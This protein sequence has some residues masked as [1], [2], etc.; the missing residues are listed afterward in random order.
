MNRAGPWERD[1]ARTDLLLDFTVLF[2]IDPFTLVYCSALQM[3]RLFF[4][5]QKEQP[6]CLKPFNTSF[7]QFNYLVKISESKKMSK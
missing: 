3:W 7:I 4:G 6:G 1:T 2:N 5:K